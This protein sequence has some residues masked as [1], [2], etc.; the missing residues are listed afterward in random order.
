[1]NIKRVEWNVPIAFAPVSKVRTA[2]GNA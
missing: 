1:M 2:I